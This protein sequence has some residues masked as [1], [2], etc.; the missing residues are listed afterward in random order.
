MVGGE[1]FFHKGSIFNYLYISL[2]LN[3]CFQHDY[4]KCKILDK[5]QVSFAVRLMYV[6]CYLGIIQY[7]L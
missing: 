2:F 4:L 1:K 5:F 3:F 7:S 6:Y